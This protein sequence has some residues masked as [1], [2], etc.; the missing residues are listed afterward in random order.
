MTDKAY[1]ITF[2]QDDAIV[3]LYAKHVSGGDIDNMYGFIVVKGF[4]FDHH[5]KMVVDPSEERLKALFADVEETYIPMQE[6]IRID[7]VKKR[8]AGKI[9]PLS[10]GN[11][12][13]RFPNRVKSSPEG[14]Q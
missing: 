4:I 7:S 8:G 14:T 1:R 5:N 10:E 11:R 12:M 9:V 13:S 6:I 3:E 2:L